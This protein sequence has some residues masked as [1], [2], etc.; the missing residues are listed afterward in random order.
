MESFSFY[1]EM[2]CGRVPA[3]TQEGGKAASEKRVR[4][5]FC[6]SPLMQGEPVCRCRPPSPQAARRL[7]RQA[8]PTS[9]ARSSAWQPLQRV[10]I[11]VRKRGPWQNG[12]VKTSPTSQR[13]AAPPRVSTLQFCRIGGGRKR[14]GSER[15]REGEK[16]N[17]ENKSDSGVGEGTEIGDRDGGRVWG[18]RA[19][20]GTAGKHSITNKSKHY[21]I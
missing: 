13:F 19:R 3:S 20:G 4:C 2:P 8:S 16:G 1:V 21:P 7:P 6:R 15:E 5:L 18:K 11:H 14:R 17:E 9:A 10:D 12:D